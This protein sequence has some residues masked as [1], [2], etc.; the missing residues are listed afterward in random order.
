MAGPL[1]AC[2]LAAGKGTRM[3]GDRPKV[4]F[5]AG[6]KPLIEWVLGAL[7]AAGCDDIVSVVGYGKDEVVS[8]LPTGVR[9]VEQSP[10]L[11]TGHAVMCAR[12]AFRGV[13]EPLV[14]TCGDMP[15]ITA[16]TYGLIAALRAAPTSG[17]LRRRNLASRPAEPSGLR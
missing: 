10:Q 1:H 5:E 6:G 9:W 3:G 13:D 11:G 14:I 8:R 16:R 17:S 2:V 15:L 7:S 12:H 4:L